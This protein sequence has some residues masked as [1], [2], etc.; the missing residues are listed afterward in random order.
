MI[1]IAHHVTDLQNRPRLSPAGSTI[2][3]LSQRELSHTHCLVSGNILSKRSYTK[4]AHVTLVAEAGAMYKIELTG[5]PGWDAPVLEEHLVEAETHIV[6]VERMAQTLLN[7]ARRVSQRM[8]PTNY[9]VI[10]GFGGFVR[11]SLISKPRGTS[12][13]RA[14]RTVWASTGALRRC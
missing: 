2:I 13:R 11:S 9:R 3:F 8:G 1:H 5:G 12:V 10:D 4:E 14:G 7:D 6:Y